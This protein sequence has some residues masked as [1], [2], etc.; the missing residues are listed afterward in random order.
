MRLFGIVFILASLSASLV[1]ALAQTAKPADPWARLNFLVGE[2]QGLGSG[3]PGEG[4][5]GTSFA[6]SLN[7][8]I[9]VRKNW[10]K[11]PAKPGEAAGVSHEDLMIIYPSGDGAAFRA[12]YFDNEGHVI[13]YAASFPQKP[14]AVNFETDPAQPGPRFRL[15]YEWK[16]D[17]MLDNLFWMAPPGGEFKVYVQGRL[18]RIK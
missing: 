4:E 17:G 9:L 10:A 5:G 13:H 14:A 6:F 15:T 16:A 12:V 7:R 3:A 2:W 18:R 11:Y 8:K 1:P